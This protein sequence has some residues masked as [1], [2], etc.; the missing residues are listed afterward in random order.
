M[1][2]VKS[3]DQRRRA[4]EEFIALHHDDLVCQG[5]V[6]P[7]WRHREGRTLGPY[8]LLR[9]RNRQGR[10]CSVYLG[11]AGAFVEEVRSMLLSLQQP[12]AH[13]RELRKARREIRSV[14]FESWKVVSTELARVGLS[15]KGAD[16]SGW[17]HGAE[18]TN[19]DTTE[20]DTSAMMI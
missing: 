2:T 1:E 9:C 7:T 12:L 10:Q 15:R 18:S 17:R 20:C 3:V 16:V 5:S 4:V 11:P 19:D 8:H 13:S 14:L 6:V